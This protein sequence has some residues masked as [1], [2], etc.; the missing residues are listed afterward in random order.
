MLDDGFNGVKAAS[1]S[2]A[3]DS[4]LVDIMAAAE[5]IGLGSELEA[6]DKLVKVS[7]FE[8]L[9][10]GGVQGLGVRARLEAVVRIRV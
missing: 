7:F 10:D 5:A 3:A 1:S 9:V 8:E 4:E 6:N 2:K